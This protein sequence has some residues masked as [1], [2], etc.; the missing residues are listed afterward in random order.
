[1]IPGDVYRFNFPKPEAD[2][3]VIGL[4]HMVVVV[5]SQGIHYTVNACPISSAK[6][7]EKDL[8][9]GYPTLVKLDGSKY[10]FLRH[11]SVILADQIFCLTTDR[12]E[13]SPEMPIGRL[14]NDDLEQLKGAI[15]DFLQLGQE[16]E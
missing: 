14:S 11:D 9:R 3:R 1:M 8:A 15:F 5:S 6:N 16:E 13:P 7:Y 2:Q 4:P 12:L 10:G